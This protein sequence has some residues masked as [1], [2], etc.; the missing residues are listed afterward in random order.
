MSV[1]LGVS[2]RIIFVRQ[3]NLAK[4]GCEKVIRIQLLCIK[5]YVRDWIE[6][7]AAALLLLMAA[8]V[9]K[10]SSVVASMN[11]SCTYLKIGQSDEFLVV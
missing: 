4:S 1:E 9:W 10:L 3:L 5:K 6:N 11:L 8:Q 2:T 7:R